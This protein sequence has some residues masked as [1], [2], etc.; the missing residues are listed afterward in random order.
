MSWLAR[1]DID[2][3]TAFAD[4]V[5]DS[6]GWHQRLWSC[7]RGQPDRKRDFLTRIDTLEGAYRLWLL[8]PC[9]PACPEW[10]P[11]ECFAA[12]E[13]AESFLSHRHYVFNLRAN[14][15]KCLVQRN[16]QGERKS[17]GKRVA[18]VKPDELR[19][20]IERKGELGGFRIVAD[21]PLDIGPMV[22]CHFRKKEQ[23]ACHGGVE[24]RGVL[25]VTDHEKFKGTYYNGIG[26]AKGFGF[27]LLLLAPVNL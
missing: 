25:E 21:R 18:L 23:A 13:I 20:W 11:P 12:K 17:R 1:I 2:A 14:A 19:A 7:F 27:G 15:V 8:S 3:Q 24:F 6:Y 10:C 22:K 26:R 4:S 9:R 5:P 16:E